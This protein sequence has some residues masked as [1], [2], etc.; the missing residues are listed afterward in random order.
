MNVVKVRRCKVGGCGRLASILTYYYCREH[1]A[2]Y[3]RR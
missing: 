3:F 2:A 1:F